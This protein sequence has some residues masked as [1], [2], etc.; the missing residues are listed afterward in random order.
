[1]KK[2]IT[3]IAYFCVLSLFSQR[4]VSSHVQQLLDDK[5]TFHPAAPLNVSECENVQTDKLVSNATY[6]TLDNSEVADIAQKKYATLALTIPYNNSLVT[7]LLYRV[8]IAATDFHIDTDKKNNFSYVP[9]AYYRGI[10]KGNPKSVAAFSFFDNEMYGVASASGISN[11]VVARLKTENPQKYIIY[12][13]SKLHIEQDFKCAT[14]EDKTSAETPEQRVAGTQSEHCVTMYFELRHNAFVANMSDITQTTNWFTSVFNNV[15]TL[16]DNDGITIALKSI[17]IWTEADPY[18]TTNPSAYDLLT[19]FSNIRPVFDGDVG[20]LVSVSFG[21]GLA[22]AVGGLCGESNRSYTNNSIY[23]DEVPTYSGTICTI[24]HELGHLLGSQ[25]THGCYWNGDNTAI[26]GCGTAAGYIEGDCSPGPIP[27]VEEGG[28]IM[29]YCNA[30]GFSSINFANGFG[31]QPAQRILDYIA[32]APCLGNDCI[33]SCLNTVGQIQLSDTSTQTA[34]LSWD[35]EG[36]GPWEIGY[37]PFGQLVANWQ[38]VTESTFIIDGLDANTYYTFGVRPICNNDLAVGAKY[39]SFSTGADWCA[40]AVWTD[41]G[42]QEGDYSGEQH[43]VTIIKP[44]SSDESVSLTFDSFFTQTYDV[45]H[46]YDGIG[47][48]APLLGSWSGYAPPS[49]PY[50]A[51]NADGALTFE[52]IT[53]P[54][55]IATSGWTATVECLLGIKENHPNTLNY[56]PNPVE[57]MLTINT[58]NAISTINIYNLAGQILSKETVNATFGIIDMSAYATGLYIIKVNSGDRSEYLKII[59]K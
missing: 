46:I 6:A 39:L 22:A 56:Y 12:S 38:E 58:S 5:T 17:Y 52:F 45:I 10:I 16:Y 53:I 51:T 14:A 43:T 44:Q 50:L 11:L 7:L 34:T 28:T 18:V 21:N 48:S 35:D 54:N 49:E 9:G 19:Q 36:G 1:V 57:K 27:S 59:K 3:I 33:S 29:S 55:A 4:R 26:D 37:A 15:Q 30:L 40:E 13:D 47:T 25:H 41:T 42:G 31:S 2:T 24:A 20:Q 32:A 23:Y 8:E